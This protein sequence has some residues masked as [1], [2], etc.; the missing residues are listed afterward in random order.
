[1]LPRIK[2]NVA[3]KEGG[4]D[5]TSAHPTVASRFGFP[6]DF[7]PI[8]RGSDFLP[9][10]PNYAKR[11]QLLHPFCSTPLL[12]YSTSAPTIPDHT[13]RSQF[14]NANC[15]SPKPNSQ[16]TRNEP[17]LPPHPHPAGFPIPHYAKRTQS[18]YGHGMPCPCP[19]HNEPNPGMSSRTYSLRCASPTKN[20]CGKTNPITALPP[21]LRATHPPARGHKSRHAGKL[22]TTNHQLPTEIRKT[23]PIPRIAALLPPPIP[24]QTPATSIVRNEP[25]FRPASILPASHPHLLCETNSITSPLL[26]YFSTPLLHFCPCHPRLHETNPISP[27]RWRLAGFFPAACAIFGF[28]APAPSTIG[29]KL[30][31]SLAA[32]RVAM[33]T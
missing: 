21:P 3:P 31:Y 26:L 27:Y 5:Q 9:T 2:D 6:S 18:S 22:R 20:W 7:V 32:C 30:S 16:K 23:N 17:N 4:A 29:R 12:H 1:M 28:P 25:N 13:K 14:P 11:T 8:H 19:A 33:G 15:Q 24:P 10:H